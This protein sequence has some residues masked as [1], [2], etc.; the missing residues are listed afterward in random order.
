MPSEP[1]A[2]QQLI[3]ALTPELPETWTVIPYARNVDVLSRPTVMVHV[4]SIRTLPAAPLGA[5]ETEFTITI[6][7]PLSDPSRAQGAL[8]DEVAELIFALRTL[9]FLRFES[10]EPTF[11][12]DYLSWDV[13][14]ITH[15]NRKA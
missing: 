7:D 5:L 11:V 1:T 10:A 4:T 15:T 9:T 8:D 13:K 12:Q 2:R 3:E 6:M 14:V